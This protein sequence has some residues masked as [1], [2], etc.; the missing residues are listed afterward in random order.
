MDLYRQ[1][2]EAVVTKAGVAGDDSEERVPSQADAA[3]VTSC[4][5]ELKKLFEPFHTTSGGVMFLLC[6]HGVIYA[7]KPMLR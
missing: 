4:E 1:V 7:A 5:Q 2:Y 6:P 3:Q